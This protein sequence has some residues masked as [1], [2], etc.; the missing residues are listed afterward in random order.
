MKYEQQQCFASSFVFNKQY[1]EWKEK[2]KNLNTFIVRCLAREKRKTRTERS[3]WSSKG[4]S[5]QFISHSLFFF[6]SFRWLCFYFSAIFVV[7]VVWYFIAYGA[8]S[9]SHQTLQNTS[10]LI[11]LLIYVHSLKFTS[12]LRPFFFIFVHS[13]E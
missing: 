10:A 11:N 13:N 4:R 6:Y 9:L 8:W 5:I 1:I 7:V 2:N 3:T 12:S